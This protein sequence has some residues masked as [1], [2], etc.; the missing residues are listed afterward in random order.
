M[1]N[2][3]HLHISVSLCSNNMR[4]F[5]SNFRYLEH[6]GKVLTACC[7]FFV[8]FHIAAFSILCIYGTANYYALRIT[9]GDRCTTQAAFSLRLRETRFTSDTVILTK[10][11]ASNRHAFHSQSEYEVLL[12]S[13]DPSVI[14]QFTP[15]WPETMEPIINTQDAE[16]FGLTIA[17]DSEVHFAEVTAY[18]HHRITRVVYP[19]DSY[20][21]LY[22]RSLYEALSSKKLLP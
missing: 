10:L 11:P 6:P 15:R 21:R 18:P 12:E 17:K 1:E 4:I 8:L 5:A 22:S 3:R 16:R 9:C 14:D 19:W 13:S 2:I 20:T 7:I